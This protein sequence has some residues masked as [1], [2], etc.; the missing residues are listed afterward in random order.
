MGNGIKWSAWHVSFED[1]DLIVKEL[2]EK[3]KNHFGKSA[4]SVP[5]LLCLRHSPSLLHFLVLDLNS[6]FN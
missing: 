2:K 5:A 3:E 1:E 6:C 4:L